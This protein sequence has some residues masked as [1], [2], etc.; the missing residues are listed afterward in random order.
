MNFLNFIQTKRFRTALCILGGVIA[1]LLI[2]QAGLSVGYRKAAFS[3]RFG[4]SYYRAFGGRGPGFKNFPP[5]EFIGANGAEGSI[6]KIS[7][8][9]FVI[10][11]SDNIEKV[12]LTKADTIFRRFRDEIKA[13]DL[14]E[15]DSV[16]VLGT[17]NDKGQ[18]EAK[19]IRIAPADA[20][21]SSTPP[22]R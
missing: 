21:A 10:E 22:T 6:V 9:T 20:S 18:I 4:D 11:G 14:K 5:D 16:I 17:P 13:A 3:Y 15:G 8:P 7:L 19:L 2:F 1:A 12:I